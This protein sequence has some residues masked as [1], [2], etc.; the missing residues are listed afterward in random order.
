VREA[1]DWVQDVRQWCE[2]TY[3]T[4]AREALVKL[5]ERASQ[6]IQEPLKRRAGTLSRWFAPIVR[7]IR[8]R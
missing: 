7:S 6:S 2:H 4:P 3:D 8:H 1:L 5:L